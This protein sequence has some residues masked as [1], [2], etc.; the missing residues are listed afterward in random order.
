ML[1]DGGPATSSALMFPAGVAADP[2]G[3]GV[4]LIADLNDHRIRMVDASGVITTLTGVGQ[5][6]SADGDIGVAS[7][8]NPGGITFDAFYWR[9]TFSGAYTQWLFTRFGGV[10]PLRV[11]PPTQ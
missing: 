7:V 9:A 2:R 11:H 1:A 4:V 3:T 5:A 10:G 6:R 8:D